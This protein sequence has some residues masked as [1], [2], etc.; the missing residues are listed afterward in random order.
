MFYGKLKKNPAI[1]IVA[2]PNLYDIST[3]PG[4]LHRVSV[5]HI[6]SVRFGDFIPYLE[7]VVE[8][9]EMDDKGKLHTVISLEPLTPKDVN[10]PY[11][12]KR[13]WDSIAT[14]WDTLEWLPS[15]LEEFIRYSKSTPSLSLKGIGKCHRLKRLGYQMF[16]GEHIND[17]LEDANGENAAFPPSLEYAPMSTFHMSNI[18]NPNVK[19]YF[20]GKTM[21]TIQSMLKEGD[22]LYTLRSMKGQWNN[23]SFWGEDGCFYIRPKEVSVGE[24]FEFVET[25]T[26]TG[27]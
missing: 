2:P 13:L 18:V 6:D 4:P 26:P 7:E 17:S 3:A 11:S 8:V 12:V 10:I 15:E 24:P 16:R 23:L 22:G 9:A 19:F 14:E 25:R 5:L 20:K 21:K 1:L 27:L